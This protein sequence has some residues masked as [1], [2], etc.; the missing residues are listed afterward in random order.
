MKHVS[1]KLLPLL[2]TAVASQSAPQFEVS[3]EQNLPVVYQASNTEVS[4]PGVLLP[5]NC[6]LLGMSSMTATD[7]SR[8]A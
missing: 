4:P 1:P 3:V 6:K 2:I 7:H 8:Y 5:R